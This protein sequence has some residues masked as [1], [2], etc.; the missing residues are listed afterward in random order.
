MG[1]HK[2]FERSFL[3]KAESR[4]SFSH[5]RTRKRVI[6]RKLHPFIENEVLKSSRNPKKQDW[7]PV[8]SETDFFKDLEASITSAKEYAPSEIAAAPQNGF[9]PH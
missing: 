9:V 7:E 1:L 6:L 4:F 2:N 3:H 8:I 5:S